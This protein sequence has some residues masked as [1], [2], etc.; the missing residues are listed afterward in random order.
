[1]RYAELAR[2]IEMA[3]SVRKTYGNR[4]AS[5]FLVNGI[6]LRANPG[7]DENWHSEALDYYLGQV[8]A[9]LGEVDRAA[10]YFERSHTLP[11]SGGNLMFSDQ[12]PESLRLREQQMRAVSRGIP[13]I[14]IASMPRSASASL[15]QS[16]ASTLDIPIMRVSAG[17]FPLFPIVPRRLTHFL[18]GGA[19]THDH[20]SAN[21]FNLRVLRE[22]G[23]REIFVLVRDPRAASGSAVRLG[24][25]EAQLPH[26]PS[27][28]GRQIVHAALQFFIPWLREWI[29]AEVAQSLRVHWVISEQARADMPAA[30]RSIL[31]KFGPSHPALGPILAEEIPQV[32]ANFVRGDDDAWRTLVDD[33]GRQRLWNAIPARARELFRLEA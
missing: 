25:V 22:V 16:I 32:R 28:I 29:G 24:E 17:N 21:P 8:C 27:I 3:E 11:H 9:H 15:T 10:E 7:R 2:L 23:V 33:E 18:T 13:A 20:M 1:V 19:I 30:V 12:V 4:L 5:D 26:K 31:T 14:L 6:G